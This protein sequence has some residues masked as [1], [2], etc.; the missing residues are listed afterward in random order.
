MYQCTTDWVERDIYRTDRGWCSDTGTMEYGEN[1]VKLSSLSGANR[2][3][4]GLLNLRLSAHQTLGRL[5]SLIVCRIQR[6]ER[7]TD[8]IKVNGL[9][10]C[11]AIQQNPSPQ[12]PPNS[13]WLSSCVTH[14]CAVAWYL[15]CLKC[16]DLVS[17]DHIQAGSLLVYKSLTVQSTY[18]QCW[19]ANGTLTFPA[20]FPSIQRTKLLNMERFPYLTL[21]RNEDSRLHISSQGKRTR[22][23]LMGYC[24]QRFQPSHNKEHSPTF[25]AQASRFMSSIADETYF[26]Q[27]QIFSGN[28]GASEI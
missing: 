25:G 8:I 12:S 26:V 1:A 6:L 27:Q 7:F 15:R 11:I 24:I 4:H 3:L 16:H 28:N 20:T 5:P 2:T 21:M 14:Q 10:T 9:I 22:R 19:L 13:P 18:P 23:W 17:K